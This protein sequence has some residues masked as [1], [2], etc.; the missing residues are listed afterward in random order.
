[1]YT[2]F[3]AF[4]WASLKVKKES[5]GMHEHSAHPH[6]VGVTGARNFCERNQ[7]RR[8]HSKA[9]RT[10]PLLAMLGSK[11]IIH[12]QNAEEDVREI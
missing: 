3:W 11:Q 1:M 4:Q 2:F 9:E 5:V 12:D 6:A 7:R 10:I 8:R